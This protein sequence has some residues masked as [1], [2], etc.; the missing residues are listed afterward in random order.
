MTEGV[1]ILPCTCDHAFQDELYGHGMRV[2]NVSAKA[3]AACTVCTVNYRINRM[4][5][6]TAQDPNKL[7]GHG[8]IPARKNR[9]TKKVAA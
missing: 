4:N 3:E 7:V 2:H 9:I 1:R 8:Y 5:Q 6:P